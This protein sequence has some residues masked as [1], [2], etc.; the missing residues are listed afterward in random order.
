MLIKLIY[1]IHPNLQTVY[2]L[3]IQYGHYI[4]HSIII[5]SILLFFKKNKLY[6]CLKKI[7]YF[8]E[9]PFIMYIVLKC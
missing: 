7:K 8:I 5:N 9:V 6:F 1:I 3:I 2:T 4:P